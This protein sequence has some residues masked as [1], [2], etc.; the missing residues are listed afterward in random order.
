MLLANYRTSPRGG[1]AQDSLYYLGQS[2]MKLNQP[3]QAC[4]AYAE[5]TSV[6][7]SAVRAGLLAQVDKARNEANCS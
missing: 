7:G 2:L 3:D 4:K 5:L 6:Y 1:R